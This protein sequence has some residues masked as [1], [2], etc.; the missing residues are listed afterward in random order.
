MLLL[1]V[2]PSGGGV[3]S[4]LLLLAVVVPPAHSLPAI[5]RNLL[6]RFI[7]ERLKLNSFLVK[8]LVT[9]VS[10]AAVGDGCCPP[11]P[12]IC[13]VHSGSFDTEGDWLTP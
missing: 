7:S 6:I 3:G 13:G 10:G 8:D 4:L 9:P 2:S 5:P 1:K 11:L 12:S